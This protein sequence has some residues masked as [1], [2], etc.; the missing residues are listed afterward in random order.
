M[1]GVKKL[2]NGAVEDPIPI[3]QH[4]GDY[5]NVTL[6]A[7]NV[8]SPPSTCNLCLTNV[9]GYNQAVQILIKLLGLLETRYLYML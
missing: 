5:V 2:G 9:L 3:Q 4:V 8:D 6:H 1:L 7:T